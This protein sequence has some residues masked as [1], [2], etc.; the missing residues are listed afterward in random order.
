MTNKQLIKFAIKLSIV[1]GIISIDI[2]I[3]QDKSLLI[4]LKY[5]L[6]GITSGSIL[7]AIIIISMLLSKNREGIELNEKGSYIFL[8]LGIILGILI[9]FVNAG[10]GGAILGIFLGLIL[11]GLSGALIVYLGA[12]IK[13]FILCITDVSIFFA[14]LYALVI[15]FWGIGN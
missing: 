9:G 6:I 4:I 15:S 8:I 7:S 1:A 12:L 11:G 3:T 2:G 10:I 5:A 14:I 13:D